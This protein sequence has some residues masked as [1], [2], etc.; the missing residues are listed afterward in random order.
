MKLIKTHNRIMLKLSW[1]VVME[2]CRR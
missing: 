1:I 2:K